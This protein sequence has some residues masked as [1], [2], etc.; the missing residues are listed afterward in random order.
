MQNFQ[1]TFEARKL[2][3]ISEGK[4]GICL[5]RGRWHE[6][7]SKVFQFQWTYMDLLKAPKFPYQENLHN[8][9]HLCLAADAPK[10]FYS[11][12]FQQALCYGGSYVQPKQF[13]LVPKNFNFVL[14]NF[15]L[16]SK[17]FNLVPE[18][19]NLV[20][21][22]FNLVPKTFNLVSRKLNLVQKKQSK[23]KKIYCQKKS[24][25]VTKKFKLVQKKF[26]I[27]LKKFKIVPKKN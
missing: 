3:F 8:K 9:W 11:R 1:D 19:F 14:K 4:G 18:N 26:N 2:L 15:N 21:K 12:C 23:T 13:N 10:G 20:P 16:V 5:S 17:K 25:S 27:V 24:K 6:H 22:I 7:Y